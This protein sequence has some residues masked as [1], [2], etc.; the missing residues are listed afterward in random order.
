MIWKSNQ[1][2]TP[3]FPQ[4]FEEKNLFKWKS[5]KNINY[6]VNFKLS[7]S[8]KFFLTSWIATLKRSFSSMN[9]FVNSQGRRIFE[10]F[11]TIVCPA[12]KLF[13]ITEFKMY[14]SNVSVQIANTWCCF[15]T[16]WTLSIRIYWIVSFDVIFQ[17]GFTHKCFVTI[18][19][20]IISLILV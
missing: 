10:I 20:R 1:D 11:S 13:F 3:T 17:N 9:F 19:A 18:W 8:H 7:I 15:W 4:N 5:L 12:D 16:M 2:M 6:H 14:T